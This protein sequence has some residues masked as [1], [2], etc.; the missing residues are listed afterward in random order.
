VALGWMV[1]VKWSV[2]NFVND[3]ISRGDCPG[4]K[5]GEQRSPSDIENRKR[6]YGFPVQKEKSRYS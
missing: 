5:K 2:S 6:I 1:N 4:K 3:V